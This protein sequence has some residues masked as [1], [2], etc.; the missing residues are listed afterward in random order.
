VTL[1]L[2]V[3]LLVLLINL[4]VI[5]GVLVRDMRRRRVGPADYVAL[6]AIALAAGL[7]LAANVLLLA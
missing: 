4:G 7:D 1:A 3:L 2:V 5:G 6:T